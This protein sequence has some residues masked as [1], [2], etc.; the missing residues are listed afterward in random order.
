MSRK[1]AVIL[2]ADIMNSSELANSLIF[3]EYNVFVEEFQQVMGEVLNGN[4]LCMKE[5]SPGSNFE[6]SIRGDEVCL[7]LYTDNIEEDIKTVFRVAVEMKRKWLTSKKNV[8]RIKDGRN[9]IDIGIGVNCGY[10]IVSD[11]HRIVGKKITSQRTAEGYSINLAK[12]IEGYSREGDYSKI[13]VSRSVFNIL[14]VKFQIAFSRVHRA[15]FKGIAQRIPI[16]E[17]KSV[18]HVEQTEFPTAKLSERDE[19]IY[20]QAVE[21][22]PHD[23]WLILDLA[24]HYFDKEEYDKAVET[25][26]LAI[27]VDPDFS[28]AH[29]YLGRAHFRNLMYEDALPHIEQARELN[30]ESTRANNFLA[31]CLR[32]LGYKYRQKGRLEWKN[33]YERALN[34]HEVAMRIAANDFTRY[35]WA[36]NAFALTVADA[37]DA[38]GNR[39]LEEAIAPV[40][41]IIILALILARKIFVLSMFMKLPS[42]PSTTPSL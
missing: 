25:Y 22:N 4:I 1:R 9:I 38:R 21:S 15:T 23:L 11:H 12:R 17:V 16:Y 10:L 8:Q 40:L 7:I 37:D 30:P 42:T 5:Y 2:F 31:V 26:R 20:D 41:I 32:R 36:F 29:M 19:E 33:Y 13:F 27:E 18:G 35:Q 3:E 34:F 39:S 14:R 24:H 6:A 28:P